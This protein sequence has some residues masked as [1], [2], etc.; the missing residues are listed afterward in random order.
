M[1]EKELI[2]KIEILHQIRP[3][4]NWVF[5]TKKRILGEE[6]TLSGLFSDSLRVFQ[7]LFYQYKFA[8]VSLMLVLVLGGTFAFAQKSLPGEALFLVKK[9]TEKT[10]AI[11]VSKNEKPGAQLE[12]ANKRLEELNQIAQKNDAKKLAPAIEEFQASVSKAAQKLTEAKEPNVKEIV[13]V[14]KKIE[15]NK[16]KA[17]TLG[18]VVGETRDFDS[19]LLQLIEREIK[20]LEVRTLTDSQ[21]E[22][23]VKAVEDFKAGNYSEA[24]Y[25]IWL[26]SNPQQ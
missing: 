25:K 6:R 10:R 13:E 5:L 1:T 24:L 15:A 17:E 20:Y 12:L 21:K 9:I 4:K 2:G 14:T 8:L 3:R 16:Q 19:A 22:I 11:F 23:F 7:G 26:L 18:V